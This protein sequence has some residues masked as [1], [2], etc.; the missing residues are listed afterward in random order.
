MLKL[1]NQETKDPRNQET[2][3]PRNEEMMKMEKGSEEHVFMDPVSSLNY[4]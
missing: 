1:R 2:K 4:D 3:K